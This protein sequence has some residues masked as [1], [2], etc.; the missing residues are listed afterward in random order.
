MKY[1]HASLGIKCD[2]ILKCYSYVHLKAHT[3]IRLQDV[4]VTLRQQTRTKNLYSKFVNSSNQKHFV[5]SY[6]IIIYDNFV[7]LLTHVV[8][9]YDTFCLRNDVLRNLCLYRMRR[10]KISLAKLFRTARV[11]KL[12]TIL[13][14]ELEIRK[15]FN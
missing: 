14:L 7:I 9:F 13:T 8:P 2:L 12:G 11:S 3:D 5:P 4:N 6:S 10:Y 15:Q 1:I